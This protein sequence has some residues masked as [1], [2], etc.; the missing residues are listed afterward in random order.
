M[1]TKS[2]DMLKHIP[3]YDMFM[4]ISAEISELSYRKL[5]LEAQIKSK[6]AENFRIVSTDEKYFQ[7]GKPPSATYIENAY[8]YTG[9][10]N[11]LVPLRLEL[12]EVTSR[13]EEK[14]LQFDV[15]K[16][17]VDIWRTLS[18]SERSSTL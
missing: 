1:I 17:M 5:K 10:D 13:L 7:G 14:R 6:E 8:K 11:E 2:S 18:S 3:D 15:Y 9:I 4:G 16:T 12:A